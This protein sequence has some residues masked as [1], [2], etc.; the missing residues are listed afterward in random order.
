MKEKPLQLTFRVGWC[1]PCGVETPDLHEMI[2]R[3]HGNRFS[4][5]VVWSGEEPHLVRDYLVQTGDSLPLGADSSS[6]VAIRQGIVTDACSEWRSANWLSGW[7]V[8]FGKSS[9][10]AGQFSAVFKG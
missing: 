7:S 1:P 9:P 2:T 6:K 5:F 3:M 4:Y 10:G 8:D